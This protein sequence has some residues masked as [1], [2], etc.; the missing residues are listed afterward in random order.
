MLDKYRYTEKEQK[1]ILN[2]LTVLV[3]TREKANKVILDKFN[4]KKIPYKIKKLNHGDYSFFIPA[5]S[6]LNIERDIYFD[7]DICIEKKN[8][9]DEI[10]SNLNSDR[11]R[12]EKEFATYKGK[13]T[14][15]IENDTYKDLCEGNYKSKYGRSSFIGTLHSFAERYNMNF[16]FI[17]SEYSAEYIYC[18]FYYYLRE[19]IK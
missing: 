16:I 14:L 19:L 3:D 8:S 6:K 2:S 11:S 13:M 17:D 9:L 18:T 4:K 5:N 15:M 12:L 1:E 7:K 10:A